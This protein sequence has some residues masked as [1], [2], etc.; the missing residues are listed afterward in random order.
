MG[1]E[2]TAAAMSQ[3][4]FEKCRKEIVF[5]GLLFVFFSGQGIFNSL[6]IIIIIIIIVVIALFQCQSATRLLGRQQVWVA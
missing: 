3:V 4:T 6:L 5:G 2:A 1:S